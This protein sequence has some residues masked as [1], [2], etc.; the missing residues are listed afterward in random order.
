MAKHPA[1]FLDR[2]GTIIE[3]RGHLRNPADLVLYPSSI[4]ALK[5]LQEYFLLFIITNQS[6]IST[7]NLT[8]SEV[9][10]V[11][12]SLLNI[13]K[14]KNV[15]I[16]DV[17]YC[18]HAKEDNCSCR[19]PQPYFILKAA[20]EYNLDLDKSFIMGDHPTDVI[21]GINAGITPVYLRSGHGEKHIAE[22]PSGVKVCQNILAASSFIIK[23]KTKRDRQMVKSQFQKF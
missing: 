14:D 13:L 12:K 11:N 21:C 4:R 9:V 6:G 15:I 3:D 19:K 5:E 17:F 20:M 10:Q 2:D 8:H 18:P 16:Y 22:V 1:I 7:G 23:L